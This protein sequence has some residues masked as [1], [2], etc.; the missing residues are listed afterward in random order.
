MD[1]QTNLE[2]QVLDPTPALNTYTVTKLG[3]KL[4]IFAH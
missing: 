2:L 3:R 1:N 4:T